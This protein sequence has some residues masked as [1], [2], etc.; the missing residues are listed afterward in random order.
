LVADI[1]L[2]AAPLSRRLGRGQLV[3]GALCDRAGR[4]PYIVT[5]MITKPP[6]S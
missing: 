3:T 4:K 6:P 2:I 5:G 1:G